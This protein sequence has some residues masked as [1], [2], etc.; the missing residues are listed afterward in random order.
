MTA[1]T[2]K[3]QQS[4]KF[5]IRFWWRRTKFECWATRDPI[6]KRRRQSQINN[7][8]ASW[9]TTD[10]HLWMWQKGIVSEKNS[11]NDSADNQQTT[12]HHI[13]DRILVATH[14]FECWARQQPDFTLPNYQ[15][16]ATRK[17][18]KSNSI[19]SIQQRWQQTN[20][21]PMFA[22]WI[23]EAATSGKTTIKSAKGD[24]RKSAIRRILEHMAAAT[25]SKQQYN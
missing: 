19:M 23:C 14:E 24:N 8:T 15:S 4:N 12:I 10:S 5:R 1:P 22:F 3:K 20:N 9:A 6:F 25:T 7:P 21:N 18:Q 2:N 16:L 13:L 11:C 17:N